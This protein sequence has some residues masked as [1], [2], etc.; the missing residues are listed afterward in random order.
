M[1]ARYLL[2]LDTRFRNGKWAVPG[3]A[4][5]ATET[6]VEALT[7]EFHE[8]TGFRFPFSECHHLYSGVTYLIN[9]AFRN[10]P[11]ILRCYK[12]G[13]RT[14]SAFM[15][16]TFGVVTQDENFFDQIAMCRIK[17]GSSR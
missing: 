4:V 14:D 3:G 16:H 9:S 8:K 11:L 2:F 12:T 17:R 1:S 5:G 6:A 15:T 13:V 7:R 10:A